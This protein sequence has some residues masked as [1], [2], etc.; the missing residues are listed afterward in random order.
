MS[1][2]QCPKYDAVSA[3]GEKL[4]KDAPNPYRE[5]DDLLRA[6]LDEEEDRADGDAGGDAG[7]AGG[8]AASASACRTRTT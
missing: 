5:R 1:G 6:L 8:P 2:G 7:A 4:P 3:A